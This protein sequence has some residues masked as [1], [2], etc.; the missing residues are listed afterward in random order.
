MGGKE[1]GAGSMGGMTES[2]P[3][4]RFAAFTDPAQAAAA[5]GG[6]PAGI[7]LDAS[8]LDDTAMQA[9]AARIGYAETAFIVEPAID[10]DTRHS[11]LRFF[12]PV[13]EV[14][15]CGHAT[16]ATAVA[17]AGRT[18]VGALTFETNVG[19]ITID[20]RNTDAGITASFTSVEPRVGA[21]APGVLA[22]LLGLLGVTPA[23]LHPDYPPRLSFAGN[24]H[25][26][27]VFAD[28]D[29]FDSFTFD[30]TAM[31]ALM[32]AQGWAGTVTT[33]SVQ[34]PAGFEARNLFP[35]GTMSEDPATGSAAASVGGYLRELGRV[36]PPARVVIRQGRHVGRPSL[37][38]VDVPATGGIVVSGGAAEI[39]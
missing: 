29:E 30:P 3:V 9:I 39:G 16:V 22:T 18:G 27:L 37:L 28:P 26:V 4:L 25:P 11:R 20:T 13:A 34:G 5:D 38:L 1:S 8:G 10:G 32:D 14:P 21:I 2:V 36:A 17:Q 6:N 12:S 19:P 24:W 15:F 33:L 23:A 7:V 31:R 35:V